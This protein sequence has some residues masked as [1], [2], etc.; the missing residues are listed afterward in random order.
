MVGLLITFCLISCKKQD[1]PVKPQPSS[2]AAVMEN[3][4]VSFPA[5]GGTAN[6]IVKGGTDGWW[7]TMPSNTWCQ[8]TKTYGSGDFKIPVTIK[9]NTTGVAREITVTINP[10]FSLPAVAIKLMQSN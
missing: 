8:V 9:A 10:T 5:G 6:I 2:F 7:V 3:N 4:T 1:L